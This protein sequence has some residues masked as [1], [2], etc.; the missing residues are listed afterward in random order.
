MKQTKLQWFGE[1]PTEARRAVVPALRDLEWLIPAWCEN[2]AL[3]WT[4][5]G[6]QAADGASAS[7]CVSYEYRWARIEFHPA[8]LSDSEDERRRNTMHEFLHIFVAP[9]AEYAE[10]FAGRLLKEEAPKFHDTVR[11]EIRDRCEMVVQD[12]RIA[13]HA[14]E[15]GR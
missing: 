14:R 13:I 4:P 9:L 1:W 7:T 10:T 11:T 3:R 8:F 15:A 6:D 12:L 2:V 5:M